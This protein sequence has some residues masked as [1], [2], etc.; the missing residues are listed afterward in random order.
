MDPRRNAK[1]FN[2]EALNDAVDSLFRFLCI[3]SSQSGSPPDIKKI[4]TDIRNYLQRRSEVEPKGFDITYN[5]QDKGEEG[6]FKFILEMHQ[7]LIPIPG[8]FLVEPSGAV[9]MNVNKEYADLISSPPSGPR[10]LPVDIHVVS[11]LTARAQ[12]KAVAAS[13]KSPPVEEHKDSV[14]TEE[15]KGPALT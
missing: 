15:Y 1:D 6:T 12:Q 11:A 2:E 14:L 10:P 5:P 13:K 7:A 4:K 3:R 8:I 9:S